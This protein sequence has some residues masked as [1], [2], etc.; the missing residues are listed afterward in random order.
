M[1]CLVFS[2]LTGCSACTEQHDPR[3]DR[4]LFK[5]EENVGN[6][7]IARLNED[8]SLPAPVEESTD[9]AAAVAVAANP[10]MEKYQ[11]FCSACHGANGASDGP[12]AMAMNPKPRNLT[13]PAWQDSVDDA[14][15]YKVLKE[16][17]TAIG[18]SATMAAWGGVLSDDEINEM[19]KIVRSFR[20]E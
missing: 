19:V 17:G 12:A 1:T 7:K 16:G 8:G 6:K 15:I 13:D 14:R 10:V 18:I 3:S 4:A 5:Q 2:V 11:T 9:D 20:K